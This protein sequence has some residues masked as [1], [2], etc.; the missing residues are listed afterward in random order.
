MA[1]ADGVG[2]RKIPTGLFAAA[3]VSLGFSGYLA[4]IFHTPIILG[5]IGLIIALTLLNFYG[6]KESAKFAIIA[7]LIE[8]AGLVIIV[9]IGLPYIGSVNLL[10]MPHGFPGVLSGAALIFFAYI[11]FEEIVKLS[12]ETKDPERTIPLG[13]LISIAI[14]TVV[15]I[16]VALSAVG[17]LGWQA[18]AASS[19][20]L[21]SVAAKALGGEAFFILSVIALFATANTVL[22]TL[23]ASSRV[24]YGMAENRA[25]PSFFGAV[26]SSRRTPYIAVAIVGILSAIFALSAKIERV[27]NLT[28]FALFITFFLVNA[29]V[30]YLRYKWP[31]VRRPFRIPLNIGKFPILPVIGIAASFLMLGSL[32]L[33]ILAYGGLI[34]FLGFVAFELLQRK[35][36]SQ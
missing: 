1:V 18:L 12:E 34:I 21:A 31:E 28:D 25:F 19:A 11:G 7:T 3:T 2:E 9:L 22:F 14:T 16:L 33:E 5:A 35:L 6:I 32:N 27:A 13:L 8:G 36:P 15:Y 24:V 20:P 26:H 30:I 17:I 4:A 10:E 23:V 29:S